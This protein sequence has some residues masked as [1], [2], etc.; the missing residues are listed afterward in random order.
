MKEM[1]GIF[2]VAWNGKLYLYNNN[3]DVRES[4][5]WFITIIILMGREMKNESTFDMLFCFWVYI[6]C[7][8]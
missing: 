7:G 2:V 5:K 3:N 8:I 1:N 6:V 4:L